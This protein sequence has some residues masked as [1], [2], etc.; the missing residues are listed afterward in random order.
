MKNRK[1][2][3]LEYWKVGEIKNWKIGKSEGRKIPRAVG[4]DRIKGKI[5]SK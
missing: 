3:N 5:Q 2:G 4:F 1:I